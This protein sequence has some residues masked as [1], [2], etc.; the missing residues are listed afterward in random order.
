MHDFEDLIYRSALFTLDV[1]EDTNSKIIEELQTSGSK[2]LVKNLQ[3]IRLDKAIFAIGMFSI[4]DAILQDHLSC[5]NGFEGAKKI[6]NEKENFELLNRFDEFICAINVLKHGKGRSYETLVPKYEILPFKIKLPGEDFFEEGDASEIDTLIDV[7][8]NF[9]L[10]CA[11]LIEN[12][13]N[14]IRS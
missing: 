1:L 13:L 10:K 5:R 3:M 6:L 9:V 4:F 11:K 12:V 2:I 7:D 8:D 14:E